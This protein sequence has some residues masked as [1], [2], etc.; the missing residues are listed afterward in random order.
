MLVHKPHPWYTVAIAQLSHRWGTGVCSSQSLRDLGSPATGWVGALIHMLVSRKAGASM[1]FAA[2]C[3]MRRCFCTILLAILGAC[4][5]HPDVTAAPPQDE[6]ASDYF[7]DG[8]GTLFHGA[9]CL[10]FRADFTGWVFY[11]GGYDSFHAGDHVRAVGW[12]RT[13]CFTYCMEGDA[14][15]SCEHLIPCG[16][17]PVERESWGMMKGRYR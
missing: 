11:L 13:P 6:K 8:C 15:L 12:A 5:S 14:C 4:F 7:Y 17:V 16:A 3:A 9:T 2:L 10:L 1:F